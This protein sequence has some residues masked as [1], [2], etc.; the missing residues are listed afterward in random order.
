MALRDFGKVGV[1]MGGISSEREIS[2]KSGKAVLDALKNAGVN[3]AGIDIKSEDKNQLSG[4]FKA[5]G[6]DC[7]F[8]ALHGRFGEDGQIQKILEE[9]NI[10]YT[11]SGVSASQ[12]AMDKIASL[13][14]LGENGLTIPPWESMSRQDYPA[15]GDIS[16]Q[17]GFPLVIKPANHGSS[18]GLSIIDNPRLFRKACDLAFEYDQR[19]VIQ[20]YIK[21]R[22]LTVG[23]L[24]EQ[25]LPVVEII[26]KNAYF[27]FQA[28]YQSGLTEYIVPAELDEP[29][30]KKV[31]L[32]GLSAH[33]ALGCFGCSRADMILSPEGL[34][35]LLEV[36]TI[37]GMTAT[38]L[39][40]KAARVTGVNFSDLCL[41]LLSLA[42]E[43]A[44]V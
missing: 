32:A 38:S 29:L 20:K 37:P 12:L 43:K 24:D 16:V 19:I 27:D 21:G 13:K 5:E 35:Y 33:K 42:Y 3:A 36:N 22:E 31:Q 44:K 14:V 4:M 9:L 15:S 34:V 2:L 7:A 28:K 41:K 18:I 39:L 1:L 23:V 26:T 11:G 30:R 17:L 40:P 8:I 25:P 10:P 6:L